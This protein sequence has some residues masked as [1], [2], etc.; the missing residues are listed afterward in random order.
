MQRRRS[1]GVDDG[2]PRKEIVGH[3]L[4]KVEERSPPLARK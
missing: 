3:V 2:R 4:G 1:N